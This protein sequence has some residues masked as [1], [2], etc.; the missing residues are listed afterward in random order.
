MTRDEYNNNYTYVIKFMLHEGELIHKTVQF[1]CK[2]T[3]T[4]Q[5]LIV[6]PLVQMFIGH[7]TVAMHCLV[8]EYEE[9]KEIGGSALAMY[10]CTSIINGNGD[11]INEL[12]VSGFWIQPPHTWVS[13]SED[14]TSDAICEIL[15][16]DESW[17]PER[18]RGNISNPHKRDDPGHESTVEA[19]TAILQALWEKMKTNDRTDH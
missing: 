4:T 9:D 12:E 17:E 8:T 14:Y 1:P 16:R 13:F 11:E 3:P 10:T 6:K 15:E 2:F 7:E 18:E 19:N 5:H